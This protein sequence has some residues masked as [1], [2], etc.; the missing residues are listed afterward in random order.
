MNDLVILKLIFQD[1]INY[2]NATSSNQDV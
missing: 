1:F 2:Q